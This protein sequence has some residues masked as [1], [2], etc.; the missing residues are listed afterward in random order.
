M[1][2]LIAAAMATLGAVAFFWSLLRTRRRMSVLR[3]QRET[4]AEQR[5]AFIREEHERRKGDG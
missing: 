2:D 5:S 3:K 4:W 1:P